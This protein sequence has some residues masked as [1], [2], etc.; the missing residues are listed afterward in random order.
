[1]IQNVWCFKFFKL[2][3]IVI[4]YLHARARGLIW[5]NQD[6]QKAI[7]YLIPSLSDKHKPKQP[8]KP[9]HRWLLESSPSSL[10]FTSTS[11]QER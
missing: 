3:I 11:K 4:A 8:L 7:G 6:T 1:M 9:L 2:Y 10:L 5:F